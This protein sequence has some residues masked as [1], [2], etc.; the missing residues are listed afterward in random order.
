MIEDENTK[1]KKIVAELGSVARS[2]DHEILQ[3]VIRRNSEALLVS[4]S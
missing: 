4:A 1:L 2:C 3:A